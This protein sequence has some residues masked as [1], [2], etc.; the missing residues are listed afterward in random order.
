[1][2]HTNEFLSSPQCL[3]P[4]D[5]KDV[6]LE[7]CCLGLAEVTAEII[8]REELTQKTLEINWKTTTKN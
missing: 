3:I 8:V 1:M 4:L 7:R 2:M 6:V 5:G